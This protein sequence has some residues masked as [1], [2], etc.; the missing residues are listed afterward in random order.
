[1]DYV[2]LSVVTVALLVI[3]GPLCASAMDTD[4]RIGTSAKESY[5]FKTYLKDDA[6]TIE[7][8]KGIVTLTGTVAKDSHK[9][10]AKETVASLPGVK[11]VD[12]Q[13]ELKGE[14]TAENSDA[15]ISMNVQASLLYHR[16]LSFIKTDVQ[17]KDGVVTLRGE[18]AN[19]AQI[20]LTTAYIKDVE[21]VKDVQNEMTLTTTSKNPGEKTMGEKMGAVGKSIDDA[22]ITALVKMTLMYHR[23]TSALHTEVTTKKGV[24]TLHGKAKNAAE[25]DLVTKSVQDVH[26]VHSVVNNMTIVAAPQS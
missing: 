19:Q 18:A 25:K 22:S 3:S 10:L 5:V 2:A 12:N 16:N 15:W 23:S 11:S 26:G 8:K 24:V 13:L 6:I 21:G 7:S 20:D 4:A 9:S 17:V 14:P 1:M